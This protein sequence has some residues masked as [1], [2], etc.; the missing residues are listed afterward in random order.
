MPAAVFAPAALP[1]EKA[2]I[3]TRSPVCESEELRAYSHTLGMEPQGNNPAFCI[4]AVL[5]AL[6]NLRC[7]RF[8]TRV[9]SQMLGERSRIG[10]LEQVCGTSVFDEPYSW[11]QFSTKYSWSNSDYHTLLCLLVLPTVTTHDCLHENL[12][13]TCDVCN[14]H[15]RGRDELLMRGGHEG[16]HS[17]QYR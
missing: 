6:S 7:V 16:W 14:R 15:E 3:W 10:M 13:C 12:R 9:C 5:L 4:S 8:L 1:C 2:C 11:F 17:G